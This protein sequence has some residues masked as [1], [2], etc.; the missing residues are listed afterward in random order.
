MNRH[1][2]LQRALKAKCY[3]RM[4]WMVSAFAVTQATS[5]GYLQDPYPYRLVPG[6]A[7]MQ[8]VDPAAQALG[9]IEDAVPGEPLFK[10]NERLTVTSDLCPNVLEPVETSIGNLIVNLAVIVNAFGAKMPFVTGRIKI[11]ALESWIAERLQDNPEPGANRDPRGIYVDEYIRFVDSLTYLTGMSQ[12]C[13]VCQTEKTMTSAP[14]FKAFKQTLLNTK[15]KDKL[16]DPVEL[17]N[18]EKEL[19]AFDTAYIQD[20][21][22]YGKFLSG[23][24]LNVGRK[25][26]VLS[27][28]ADQGF[29]NSPEVTPVLNSLEE[30]WP[31]DPKQFTAMMNGSRSGSFSRGAE[32]VKG[33]VTAKNLLRAC[34]NVKIVGE[35]CGTTLGFLRTYTKGDIHK[36]VGR[37]VMADSGEV[38][39]ETLED[40]KKYIG[41]LIMTRSPQYCRYK[42][43]GACKYCA[44]ENL[45]QNPLGF[46]SAATEMS[47]EV[48]GAAMK[49][50]HGKELK[51]TYL[52]MNRILS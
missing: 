9:V 16:H 20:A 33:G 21:E 28:G 51:T 4:A 41:S 19:Q 48:L 29:T 12:L 27:L 14:G 10:F 42:D 30:G 26:M 35:D 23:K 38:L 43:D 24:I 6:P 40:A 31:T 3:E 50:M 8:F 17:A 11:P 45:A 25:K 13:A 1:E 5:N 37:R 36:L 22:N 2:Y 39:V 18:F 32:T 44:G 46:S 52:D 47:S 7:L 34:G 15:Y 49:A